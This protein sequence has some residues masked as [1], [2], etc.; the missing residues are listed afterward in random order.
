[1]IFKV[2]QSNKKESFL[3][4]L[5]LEAKTSRSFKTS[6]TT[7]PTRWCHIQEDL[8][9]Q[10]YACCRLC[11]AVGPTVTGVGQPADP[12]RA[13]ELPAAKRGQC[14]AALSWTV[15]CH[16]RVDTHNPRC[17]VQPSGQPTCNG[18]CSQSKPDIMVS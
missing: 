5:T 11:L 15:G 4:C 12:Q 17:Y 2:Q 3:D 1:M 9:L 14:Q 13:P 7:H 6:Q 16:G 8:N 10:D 18:R